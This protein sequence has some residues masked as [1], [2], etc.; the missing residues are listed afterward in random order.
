MRTSDQLLQMLDEL[1]DHIPLYY[2]PPS[3]TLM[4]YPCIR[5]T[6]DDLNIIHANNKKYS[7]M[8]SYTLTYL[9]E[10]SVDV[11]LDSITSKIINL[12]Y[13]TFNRHYVSDNIHHYVFK[14]Y[15]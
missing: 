13:C 10:E 5:V 15:Y 2:D 8:M 3:E 14:I 6:H 4:S 9:N 7:M 1:L 12:E 11:G